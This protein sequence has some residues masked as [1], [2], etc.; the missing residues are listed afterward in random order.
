MD[1]KTEIAT[2]KIAEYLTELMSDKGISAQTLIN[3]GIGKQQVYSILRMGNVQRP[4]Y[5][6]SSLLKVV[7]EIG[8]HLEFHDLQKRNNFDIID[9]EDTSMN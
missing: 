9:N 4:D 5:K 6:I 3:K 7:H 1:E 8:V 2:Q